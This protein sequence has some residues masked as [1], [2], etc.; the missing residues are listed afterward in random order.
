M[1]FL[2]VEVQKT[3]VNNLGRHLNNADEGLRKTYSEQHLIWI[4]VNKGLASSSHEFT[5]TRCAFPTPF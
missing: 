1:N 4:D 5:A 2:G 3:A